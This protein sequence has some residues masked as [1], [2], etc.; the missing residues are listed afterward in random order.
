MPM[1]AGLLHRAAA[2]CGMVLLLLLLAVVAMAAL[3]VRSMGAVG[4]CE[5]SQRGYE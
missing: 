1:M 5:Q 3:P 2:A 4:L